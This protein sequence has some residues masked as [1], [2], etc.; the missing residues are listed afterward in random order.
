MGQKFHFLGH[1]YIVGS[2]DNLGY[3]NEQAKLT[4]K[5]VKYNQPPNITDL[6]T[7]HFMIFMVSLAC[8][9]QKT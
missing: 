2:N 6:G 9:F 4:K 1:M 7:L 8:S 3:W 5:I